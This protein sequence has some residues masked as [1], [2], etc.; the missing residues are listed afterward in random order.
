MK[1]TFSIITSNNSIDFHIE[2]II[3]SIFINNIPKDSYEI[4][5]IGGDGKWYDSNKHDSN[6]K[7]ISLDESTNENWYV[8]KKNLIAD[9]ALFE[10]IVYSH[11]YFLYS[12]NW[13]DGFLRF[14]EDWDLCM[15]IV[16]NKDGS[17]FRD[18]CVY[19]DPKLNWPYGHEPINFDDTHRIMLPAYKYKKNKYMYISGGYWLAKK[20]VMLQE[21][22]NIDLKWGQSEDIEWSMRVRK[23]YKYVM[24]TNSVVSSLREKRLSADYVE[25]SE[26]YTTP[27][28]EKNI[29]D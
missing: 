22:I 26:K 19:D 12:S 8:K 7:W 24:N 13:Y 17:R 27:G 4:I 11:D 21:P 6:V 25:D 1:F 10:N 28:W 29:N 15:T 16:K 14:G 3:D 23:K 2:K 5:V 18:W 9:Y 20:H